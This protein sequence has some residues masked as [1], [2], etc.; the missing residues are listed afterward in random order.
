MNRTCSVHIVQDYQPAGYL[1]PPPKVDPPVKSYLPPPGSPKVDSTLPLSG[2]FA[3]EVRE[4]SGFLVE[5]EQRH[6][7]PPLPPP[8]V[9]SQLPLSPHPHRSAP[10][11]AAA[12]AHS[13]THP[14]AV[15]SLPPLPGSG[16]KPGSHLAAQVGTIGNA[17]PHCSTAY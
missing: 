12:Q 10:S 15:S 8:P 14:T 11:A 4:L 1:P 3:P 6:D 7:H 16:Q 5:P 9:V 17:A 13:H 2:F